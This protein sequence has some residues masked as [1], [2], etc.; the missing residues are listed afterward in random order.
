MSEN[1]NKSHQGGSSM[2]SAEFEAK[3]TEFFSQ[4][5]ESKLKLVPRIVEEFKGKEAQVLQHLHNKY[6]LGLVTEK[7]VKAPKAKAEGKS[8]D[9]AKAPASGDKPKSKKKLIIII[10]VAVVVVALGVVGFLFK[11]KILGKPA[12]PAKTEAAPAENQPAAEAPKTET[13]PAAAAPAD[14]VPPAAP[15]SSAAG[16]DTSKAE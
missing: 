1:A 8:A 6:V 10:V 4:H 14:S 16:T 13:A 12:E 5:K 9:T 3:L 15:D 11:D 7:P 2:D